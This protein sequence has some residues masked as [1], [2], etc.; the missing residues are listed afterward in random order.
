M[1]A[2]KIDTSQLCIYAGV[3]LLLMGGILRAVDSFVLSAST[4]R[5]LASWTGPPPETP[6]GAVRQIV[7]DTTAP[8]RIVTPPEWLGWALL[9][10]GGVLTVHGL[11]HRW[12]K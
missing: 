5:V 8:R 10:T 2:S 3:L 1:H 12:R 4:T 7:I 9:C 11:L 6:K